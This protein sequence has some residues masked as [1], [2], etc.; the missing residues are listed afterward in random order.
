MDFDQVADEL[1]TLLPAE[2]THA[3]DDYAAQAGQ[4][5]DRPLAK[6]IRA[7]R[8]PTAG[9]W[10]AN[11]LVRR[12]PDRLGRLRDLGQALRSAQAGLAGDRLR[13]LSAQRRQLLAELTELARRDAK[14]A[15]QHLGEEALDEVTETLQAA[16]ADE[17]AIELLA[18][19][20]LVKALHPAAWPAAALPVTPLA[21]TD[22]PARAPSAP[23]PPTP[24]T[25]RRTS[26]PTPA[27][28][29]APAPTRKRAAKAASAQQ[30]Q[31]LVGARHAADEAERAAQQA[32]A[33]ADEAAR[34]AGR[35]AAAHEQAGREAEQAQADLR[36]ARDRDKQARA[37]LRR[38]A[39]DEQ[40]ALAAAEAAAAR[41]ARAQEQARSAARRLA[42]AATEGAGSDA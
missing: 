30:R 16:L 20:R 37:A 26:K 2:F 31:R 24:P 15:G 19:G 40:R 5:G 42:D 4:A 32:A 22:E 11:L 23:A 35:V 25:S 17:Q 18:R 29:Q 6:R 1:Y 33:L 3:R 8:R 28:D 9:A 13:E 27:H 12:H 7:L 14:A 34:E 21:G 36:A 38:A 39:G 10:A 41:S